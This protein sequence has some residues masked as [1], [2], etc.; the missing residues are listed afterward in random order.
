[1]RSQL[2]PDGD[3]VIVAVVDGTDCI[4]VGDIGWKWED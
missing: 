3:T 2:V 4:P 1:M